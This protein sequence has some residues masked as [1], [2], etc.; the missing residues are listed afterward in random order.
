MAGHAS[1]TT[2][3]PINNMA[4]STDTKVEAGNRENMYFSYSPFSITILIIVIL[5]YLNTSHW[6][7][8]LH[9][10]TRTPGK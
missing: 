8:D 6:R 4:K 3:M 7:A 5:P 10:A 9:P 2:A 1:M